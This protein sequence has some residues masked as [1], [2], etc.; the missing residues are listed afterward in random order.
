MK[1]IKLLPE[2][3]ASKFLEEYDLHEE[4]ALEA[5][6]DDD[7]FWAQ[8]AEE[9]LPFS[10]V[11]LDDIIEGHMLPSE[12]FMAEFCTWGFYEGSRDGE[13]F[14]TPLVMDEEGHLFRFIVKALDGDLFADDFNLYTWDIAY[15]NE[16]V[17][18]LDDTTGDWMLP[19]I[20]EVEEDYFSS[21]QVVAYFTRG[22][23]GVLTPRLVSLKALAHHLLLQR[24][25]LAREGHEAW[26]TFDKDGAL[27]AFYSYGSEGDDVTT[28]LIVAIY[29][30]WFMAYGHN[31]FL[32]ISSPAGLKT[33]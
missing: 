20:L 24:D 13:F 11:S 2:A 6:A 19:N 27:A 14:G 31:I 15:V 12:R 16:E 1:L 22:A 17:E 10:R 32:G 21:P 25:T 23:Y 9:D 30:G 18:V 8:Q 7:A 26:A 5:L 4:E 28:G 29:A 3:F 33:S